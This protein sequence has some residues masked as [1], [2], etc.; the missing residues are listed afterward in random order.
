MLS[1]AFIF[2]ISSGK[3]LSVSSSR[4]LCA[5]RLIRYIR[6]IVF[7]AVDAAA[8]PSPT[9]PTWTWIYV[10]QQNNNEYDENE[11]YEKSRRIKNDKINRCL[12]ERR[13]T[14]R[15]QQRLRHERTRWDSQSPES[16]TVRPVHTF[17]SV[18]GRHMLF[19]RSFV[20]WLLFCCLSLSLSLCPGVVSCV[21]KEFSSR[22]AYFDFKRWI[23]PAHGKSREAQEKY[24][25]W[26]LKR[27]R[28]KMKN[29]I[30][31]DFSYFFFLFV[32]SHFFFSEIA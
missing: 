13:S 4:V 15:E 22:R 20:A 23:G 9:P 1:W 17:A 8:T 18:I 11:E 10:H 19:M 5:F 14:H 7:D 12:N 28:D 21:Q 3:N 29:A 31:K 2:I 30:A 25:F 24:I 6:P 26:K 27:S 32:F 16:H